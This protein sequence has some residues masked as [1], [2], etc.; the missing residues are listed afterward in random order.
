MDNSTLSSC[1]LIAGLFGKNWRMVRTRCTSS[2]G[3]AIRRLWDAP[4]YRRRYIH[5]ARWWSDAEESFCAILR[6]HKIPKGINEFHLWLRKRTNLFWFSVG[7]WSTRCL[8][9]DNYSDSSHCAINVHIN[10]WILGSVRFFDRPPARSDIWREAVTNC[11]RTVLTNSVYW[12]ILKFNRKRTILCTFMLLSILL[13][14]LWTDRVF[15]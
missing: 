10:R 2:T 5:D 7:E 1:E 15:W 14:V 9:M 3:K 12:Y 13:T 4:E 8:W 11:Q 6:A